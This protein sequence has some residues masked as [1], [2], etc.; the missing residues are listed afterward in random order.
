[1][2]L[3]IADRVKESSTTTGT[4]TITLGGA[5]SGYQSFA[6][7]GNG[8][9]CYYTIVNLAVATEWEVGVG[10]YTASGTTLSRDTVLDSSTGAKVSFS[11]G[12]KEVFVTYPADRSVSQADVGTAPNE[13]PLNQYL[14]SM[15]YQSLEN[16]IVENLTVTGQLNARQDL[17]VGSFTWNSF[18]STPDSV[19]GRQQIV[20]GVHDKI[21]GCVLKDNG[22]VNYY[23]NPETWAQKEDG[24]A[25][26]LTGADGNVMVE[27]PKFYYRI[28]RSGTKT[29]WKV[30]AVQQSG[31]KVHPAFIKDGVEVDFR[32]YGAY[33]A[34]VFDVSGSTYL[35]GLNWDNNDGAN[36]VGVDVTAST[37]DKLASVKGIYP[38]TG[39]TR[40][41]FRTIAANVGAGWRQLDFALWSAVQMLYL[42]EYQSFFSQA[43]LGAGNTNGGYF[44]ASGSQS[45]SPHTIAGAGD[46]I[47]NGSTD[48]TSG[49]G[50]SAKPGTSFMKYRGIENFY[51]NIFNWADGINVNVT[52]AGNVHV[53]NNGAD[54]ADNTSTNMTLITSSLPTASGFIRDLLPIDGYFLSSLNAGGSSTT[55]ITDQHF[56]ATG[57]CAVRVGGSAAVGA[58]AGAFSL[59]SNDG[60]SVASRNDGGRLAY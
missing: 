2:A 6:T 60:A 42:I 41:E 23:L 49:A 57:I 50:V 35:S 33:D 32:Y 52:A 47:A 11:A 34:C 44:T 4:G 15:A 55:Y 58:N 40:A 19:F 36:G 56:A 38:M 39:L 20:T 27:I 28:E 43:I 37:G 8:N 13:I 1:M 53:T 46:A 16:V 21:R 48:T 59:A 17:L 12:N 10:T 51:G 5:V 26:V 3:I 29:T 18:T 30:S 14:G 9:Q 22:T 25:S 45:D 7:I 24:T 54:F 31:Y